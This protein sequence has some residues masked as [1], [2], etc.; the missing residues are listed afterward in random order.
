M[1]T[2]VILVAFIAVASIAVAT[3]LGHDAPKDGKCPLQQ[4]LSSGK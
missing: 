4:A 1:K 2:K 3:H